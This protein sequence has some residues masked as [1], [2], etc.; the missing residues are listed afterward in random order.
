[1]DIKLLSVLTLVILVINDQSTGLVNQT[2]KFKDKL[3]RWLNK[4][5]ESFNQIWF[6]LFQYELLK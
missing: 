1:M 3:S 4:L 6:K 5:R 2:K